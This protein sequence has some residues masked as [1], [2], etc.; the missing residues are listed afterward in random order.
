[1][2]DTEQQSSAL[3]ALERFIADNDDLIA[4]EQR[5]GRFNI[6]DALGSTRR[7][8]H[9]SNFLAWLLNPNESHGLGDLFLRAILIDLLHGAPQELRSCSPVEVD[10]C[11]LQGT[12][13]RREYRNIDLLVACERPRIVIAI[14]NKVESVEHSDQLSRYEATINTEYGSHRRMFV[15]L[16]PS[17]TVP[18]ERGWVAYSYRR[19]FNVLLRV[20]QR[21]GQTVGTEVSVVLSHYL[22]ILETRFMDDKTIESLCRRIY[23]NHRVA[24]DL[25]NQYTEDERGEIIQA[26]RD[27]IVT[28]DSAWLMHDFNKRWAAITLRSWAGVLRN[29]DGSPAERSP[30]ECNVE[31]SCVGHDRLKTKIRLVIGKS[32]DPALRLHVIR[33]LKGPPFNLRMARKE[34][35]SRWSRLHA[36]TLAEWDPDGEPPREKICRDVEIWL[37]ENHDSLCAI[38]DLVSEFASRSEKTPGDN[39]GFS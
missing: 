1:M 30:L 36:K 22:K 27:R 3:G 4:L 25:I 26:V 17:G 32:G 21:A 19:L 24:I 12:E 35:T 28:N 9:H 33:R 7:E 10:G 18:T 6:F 23:K 15:Y 39:R 38:P 13:V 2:G 31:L 37:R 5:V 14:E 16:T 11:D 34:P 29:A 8:L 20:Q